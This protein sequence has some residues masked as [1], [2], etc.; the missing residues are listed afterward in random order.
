MREWARG[1]QR[2]ANAERVQFRN[3]LTD[4]DRI[5]I[6]ERIQ[7]LVDDNPVLSSR[8]S[9]SKTEPPLWILIDMS[10][11]T[12]M[13]VTP[14]K[15]ARESLGQHQS[16]GDYGP[17][18]LSWLPAKSGAGNGGGWSSHGMT[19]SPGRPNDC[20]GSGWSSFPSSSPEGKACAG[21]QLQHR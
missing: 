18:R 8:I 6:E 10:A 12:I 1:K 7:Q 17:R 21:H 15:E 5:Q 14:M 4:E 9:D 16:Q 2:P 3:S 20:D 13:A 11:D 19:T